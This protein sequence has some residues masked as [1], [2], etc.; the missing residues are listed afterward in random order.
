VLYDIEILI[1]GRDLNEQHAF[2][3]MKTL[4]SSGTDLEKTVFLLAVHMKGMIGQELT[5]YANAV[6]SEAKIG[7]IPST[8][9]IVGTGGDG[10]HTINVSTAASI[11]CAGI[12]LR[13]AK[14]GNHAITSPQGSAD[15]MAR[16]NYRFEKSQREL[17]DH[18]DRTNFA[19]M[20]A[21][22][23]N[24]AFA[25]FFPAR[26]MLTFRTVMN[27]MGPITNPA[28]PERLV[29]GTSDPSTCELYADYLSI[30]KK[31]GF[32]VNA[33]D[34][35]DEISPISTSR[36]IMVD[37]GRKEFTVVPKEFGVPAMRYDDITFP[38]PKK[39]RQMLQEG[40]FGHDDRIAAFIALNASPVLVLNGAA[41]TL[42]EGYELAMKEIKAG[43]GKKSF[44]RISGGLDSLA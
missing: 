14:H 22:Y 42:E 24:E 25:K 36:A 9:D 7:A 3:L 17:E 30:R 19:F 40:L 16:M 31:K 32:I 39:N 15:I 27:Y 38:D 6:R 35:M 44:R 26:K 4:I 11:L 37:N 2:D 29:I 33:S 20:L 34:G 13:M 1:D 41:S 21:P 43:T 8:N 12:G 5:G 28:D 18:L 23:Y 10:M